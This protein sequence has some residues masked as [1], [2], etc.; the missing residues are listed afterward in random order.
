MKKSY[1]IKSQNIRNLFQGLF[2]QD[3]FG[4]NWGLSENLFSKNLIGGYRVDHT[5]IKIYKKV[6]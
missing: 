3:F 2:P 6:E 5:T 4:Q 1:K